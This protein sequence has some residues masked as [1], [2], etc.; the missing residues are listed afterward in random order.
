MG[1]RVNLINS[2]KILHV[3]KGEGV[4]NQNPVIDNQIRSIESKEFKIDKFPMKTSGI[5]SYIRWAIRLR[6]Y[7]VLNDID[8]IHAIIAIPLYKPYFKKASDLFFNGFRYFSQN[9]FIL[10]KIMFK[11]F[12]KATRMSK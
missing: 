3:Y 12:L 4:N 1:K 10:I 5:I 9:K 6:K 2:N 11:I 8:L 7:V